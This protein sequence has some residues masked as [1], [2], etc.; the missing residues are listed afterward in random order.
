M[1]PALTLLLLMPPVRA[2]FTGLGWRWLY[3]LGLSFTFSFSLTPMFRFIAHQY[4]FLDWPGGRKIHAEATALLGGGAVFIGFCL[5][6]LANGIFSKEV[7]VILV[8]AVLLF[9]TGTWDDVREVRASVKLLVQLACV[10]LVML[11]GIVLRV[12]PVELGV[13]GQAGNVFLTV[14]WIVG[15]TNAMN[16]FDGMDGLASGLGAVIA[17]FLGVVA[18]QTDQAFIGWIS[19]ALLGSCMGFFPYNFRLK[20]KATIFLGDGGSTTIGFILACLAVYGDWA[21]ENPIGA[22]VSPLLIFWILV[23]DMV[24]I[25]V[26]RIVTGK[27]HTF[28]EWLDYVGKDHLHHRLDHLLGGPRKSVLFIFMMNICLGASAVVLREARPIDAVIMLFQAAILVVLITVL[29]RRG[30]SLADGCGDDRD[31]KS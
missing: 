11:F 22:L 14:L 20:G 9:L 23:F 21:Q 5:S 1:I 16:F 18:F 13:L 3:I 4:E 25:T 8:S 17:F 7:A 2:F 24:H 19:V 12:F 10:G 27:V 26:D 31:D 30:R 15:I 29:E 28:K 6:I